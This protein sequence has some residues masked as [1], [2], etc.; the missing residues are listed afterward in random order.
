[1]LSATF[2]R[3]SFPGPK[4]LMMAR[5]GIYAA[6]VVINGRVYRYHEAEFS[7]PGLCAKHCGLK[8]VS[9]LDVHLSKQPCR[10]VYHRL[11]FPVNKSSSGARIPLGRQPAGA[12]TQL[13]PRAA[14]AGAVERSK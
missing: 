7:G 3:L 1:M 11:R 13:P 14:A 8:C 12:G 4:V 6:A 5:V 2:L 10:A 9:L